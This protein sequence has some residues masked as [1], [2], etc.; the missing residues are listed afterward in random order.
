MR[1]AGAYDGAGVLRNTDREAESF[2]RRSRRCAS[3]LKSTTLPQYY[4]GTLGRRT[5]PAYR[6]RS[7]SV[8]VRFVAVF[9][10]STAV[11][12]IGPPAEAGGMIVTTARDL[13]TEM[14]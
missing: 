7:L 12:L 8:A 4:S 3:A 9:S 6:H 14:P 13:Y 5:T 1:R 10:Q 11:V 2:A